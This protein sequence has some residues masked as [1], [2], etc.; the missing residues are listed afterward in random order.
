MN[1]PKSVAFT[2]TRIFSATLPAAGLERL[3]R[4]RLG[5]D[6]RTVIGNHGDHLF[7][8]LVERE[9]RDRTATCGRVYEVRKGNSDSSSTLDVAALKITGGIF[10]SS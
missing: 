1:G 8:A 7:Q 3:E 5:I 10:A 2:G 9:A 4:R 6:T